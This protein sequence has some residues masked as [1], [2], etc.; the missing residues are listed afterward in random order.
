MICNVDRSGETAEQRI[1]VA[2]RQ[3]EVHLEAEAVATRRGR[4]SGRVCRRDAG[5]AAHK[6]NGHESIDP[7]PL[8]TAG[9]SGSKPS[10]RIRSSSV[11]ATIHS[12]ELPRPQ[13][14][15]LA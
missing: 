5:T 3:S 12:W 15:L 9:Y 14:R 10:F 8:L 13:A 4:C 1:L 2:P 11:S 6:K 7:C